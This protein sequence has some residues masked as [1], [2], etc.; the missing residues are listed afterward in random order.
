MET[1]T[2]GSTTGKTTTSGYSYTYSSPQQGWECPRCGRINAPWMSQCC[3]SRGYW[4]PT[5]TSDKVYVGDKPEWWEDY[6][7]C[8]QADNVTKDSTSYTT[9]GSNHKAEPNIT[10]WNCTNPNNCHTPHYTTGTVV[11]DGIYDY[12][13]LRTPKETK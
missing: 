8:S 12:Y 10:A 2:N 3:C 5:W 7:T 4:H 13:N 1:N 11:N 9:G 6:V